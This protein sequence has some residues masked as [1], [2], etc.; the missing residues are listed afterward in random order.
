MK[1]NNN[2]PEDQLADALVKYTLSERVN[3]IGFNLVCLILENIDLSSDE[4]NRAFFE[5]A[6]AVNKAKAENKRR[7]L[8]LL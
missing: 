5:C 6:Q 2:Q 1:A 4:L 8:A 3:G 7:R